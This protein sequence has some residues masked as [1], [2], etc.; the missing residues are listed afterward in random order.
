MFE[1]ADRTHLG[2]TAGLAPQTE[3]Q[4]GRGDAKDA[5]IRD[6]CSS[7]GRDFAG[8]AKPFGDCQKCRELQFCLGLSI[9][10]F[11]GYT[12]RFTI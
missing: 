2:G 9:V 10:Q 5:I 8:F 6:R 1:D 11:E 12:Q 7:L 4:I 3:T